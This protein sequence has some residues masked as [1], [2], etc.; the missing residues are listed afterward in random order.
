MKKIIILTLILALTGCININKANKDTIIDETIKSKVKITNTYRKGYKF[1]LPSGLNVDSSKEYNEL[2]KSDREDYYLYIDLIGYLNKNKVEYEKEENIYFKTFEQNGITGYAQIKLL[3]NKKYLVEIAYNYAK[4]EVIVE[5]A[6]IK[7]CLTD[8]I[9]ILSS[10]KYNDAFLQGLSQDNLLDYS[11]ETVDIF[12][13]EGENTTNFLEAI[14]GY[15][16]EDFNDNTPQ[17]YDLIH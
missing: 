6:R 5:K 8:A 3:E 11:E 7:K 14:E 12:H 15:D 16:G 17:D 10:I 13:K 9:V 4:I 1:Y 2:I